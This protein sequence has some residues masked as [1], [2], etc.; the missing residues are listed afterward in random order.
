MKQRKDFLQKVEEEKRPDELVEEFKLSH[1]NADE[2]ESNEE[3]SEPHG[4]DL[5]A[6]VSSAMGNFSLDQISFMLSQAIVFCQLPQ[7]DTYKYKFLTIILC[8]VAN[9][10]DD[11]EDLK[12]IG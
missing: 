5:E 12:P 9:M 7:W 3:S 6:E 4:M 11:A 10:K 8:T 2:D 1:L